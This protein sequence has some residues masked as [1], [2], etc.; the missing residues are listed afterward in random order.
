MTRKFS[1][2]LLLLCV[3]L[4]CP[5]YGAAVPS[6]KPLPPLRI[7]ITPVQ[8]GI[9]PD[10]IKPGDIVEFKVTAL[11][12]IDV[13]EMSVKVELIGGA[14]L[15]SGDTSWSGPAAKNEEK[16]ITLTVQ[17]PKK[18]MGSVKARVSIPPSG[19]TRFS[20]RAEYVLGP[21]SKSKPEQEHPVKKDS[22][23]RNVIE[24]R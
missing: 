12:S 24:Y 4:S 3:F 9:T 22:K 1:L 17:A 2:Y 23:G 11:S 14:D 21:L 18:G 7:S 19:G 8:S 16:S 5:I 20:A 10:Q 13:P 15:V 6:R